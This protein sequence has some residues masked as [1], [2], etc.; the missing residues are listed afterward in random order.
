VVF[1]SSVRRS[2]D[3]I[4]RVFNV[5]CMKEDRRFFNSGRSGENDWQIQCTDYTGEER[6]LLHVGVGEIE[7][8]ACVEVNQVRKKK[9]PK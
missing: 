8:R 9:K 1:P 6:V 7:A 5:S 4:I 2:D 3:I